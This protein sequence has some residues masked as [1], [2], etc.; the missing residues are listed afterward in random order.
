MTTPIE[1]AAGIIRKARRLFVLTG[2]GMSA[3]SGVP[4]FRGG[5]ESAT[6]RGMPY[7]AL[8]SAEMIET[9][10]PLVWEWFDHR[11]S[12]LAECRPNAGHLALAAA[13][14]KGPFESLTLVTQ[15]I[16][17]L[18]SDAGS[19]DVIELHGNI[20]E[21]RCRKCEAVELI[22]DHRAEGPPVCRICN[23]A[24]RPN[25]VLFGE[26][27]DLRTVKRAYKAAEMCDVCLVVGTSAVVS[28]A[29]TLPSLA[30]GNG[31]QLIEL[32]PEETPL[33]AIADV[34]IRAPSAEV[35]ISL[36]R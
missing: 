24:M 23:D 15:N 17:G 30:I 7:T 11:R 5:G 29:N 33:T 13:Q 21:A 36:F 8:S 14:Q 6:W 31:A 3:E 18:H 28:P 26:M 19:T 25:V 1:A 12:V 35:L 2:A 22:G 27:L 10:L 20:H 4:T 32:N 34:S 9:N 16:D